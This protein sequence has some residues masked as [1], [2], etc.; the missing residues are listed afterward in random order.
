M[1]MEQKEKK[2]QCNDA[3]WVVIAGYNEE[4]RIDAVISDL[5]KNGYHNIIVVDDGSKDATGAVAADAGATVLRHLMNRGQG[6]A[7]KTGID[8]AMK[9]DA[10]IIVTFDADGQHHA[11][12]IGRLTKPIHAEE[13]DAC[14]G[15]R[16]LDTMSN[17]PWHRKMILKGGAWIIWLFYGVRLTDS[18]NG[19]RAIKREAVRKLELKA[20]RMEHA[21]E[22]VEQ[23]GKQNISYKEVPVTITYTAYS[24]EKGQSTFAAVGILWNMIKSKVLK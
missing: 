17:V 16:F 15:S 18:H 23:I 1:D 24:L 9:N 21:S 8:F 11:E 5:K 7:L 20:D 14:L 13:V 2:E 4:K 3:V 22:I 6:A 12:E 19:F 10:E